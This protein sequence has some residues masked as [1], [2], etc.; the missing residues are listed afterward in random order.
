[1]A[2][3][4]LLLSAYLFCNVALSN[5]Q[6]D[7]ES[8]IH[9]EQYVLSR[10]FNVGMQ[11]VESG[12]YRQG[13][14]YFREM[15]A[16]DPEL[17][18][19]R[20]E[21]ARAL[22]QTHQY[23]SSK[24]H[25]EIVLGKEIPTPVANNIQTY[26]KLIRSKVANFEVR[27]EFV[28]DSNINRST[29]KE[30]IYIGGLQ[31]EIN[32]DA[33]AKSQLGQAVYANGRIPI[34]AD[35]TWNI[36]GQIEHREFKSTDFDYSYLNL[37]FGKTFEFERN[38]LAVDIGRHWAGYAGHSLFHGNMLGINHQRSLKS[39]L[40][41]RNRLAYFT[42]NYYDSEPRDAS[43]Y[44]VQSGIQYQT[45]H[46]HQFKL[47]LA[48]AMH[49]AKVNFHSYR[50]PSFNAE[51]FSEWVGGWLLHVN[52]SYAHERYRESDPIFIKHRKDVERRFETSVRNR[53]IQIYDITPQIHLGR[54]KNH[55]NIGFYSWDQNYLKL[56]FSSDF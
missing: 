39:N 18:R 32:D 27:F 21:L 55:S 46:A 8:K 14:K 23:R 3:P 17:H 9:S 51:W 13:I 41:L 16:I 52:T 11:Q 24:Y 26:L 42:L 44:S 2:V 25:F 34:S 22:Y 28:N 49:D 54:V 50:K 45:N 1:M 53:K 10:L 36:N 37:N 19:P 33:Q 35:A 5:Q 15:L 31:F 43:Q 38:A 4:V 6:Q 30:F 20:L 56:S 7:V 48:Y 47:T 29:E 12:N 40:I